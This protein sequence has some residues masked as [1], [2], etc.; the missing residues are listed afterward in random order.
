MKRTA[1][2]VTLVMLWAWFPV[3]VAGQT[4]P[5][6]TPP[7]AAKPKVARPAQGGARGSVTFF[8]TNPQGR[9]LEGA[10]VAMTGPASREGTTNRDGVVTL[11][12]VRAGAYRVRVEAQDYITLERDITSR[13]GLEVEMTLNPAPKAAAPQ[14]QPVSPAQ[15]PP[16]SAA[17]HKPDPKAP[18]ESL[19]LPDW[20]EKNLIGRND[21]YRESAVGKVP[22]G[23]ATVLQV[24][25][26]VKDRSH[27]TADELIY[28]IAGEGTLH[29]NGRDTELDA[30]VL[31]VVP[32]GVV[33]TLER[34]GRNPLIALSILAGER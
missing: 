29:S 2:I 19:S 9:G 27:D 16:S 32:R 7:P 22:A 3:G 11:Q 26:P 33:F 31:A 34:R 6:T 1:V 17:A 15:P 18:V 30:G 5:T 23:T 14:P 28:V 13:S 21:P 10:I 24:R 8:V 25:D 20:I 4:P 12:G